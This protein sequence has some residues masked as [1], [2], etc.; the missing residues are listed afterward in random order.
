MITHPMHLLA[1]DLG[2]ESGRAMLGQFDGQRIEL[3]EMTRFPNV[4]VPL[5]DGLHWNTLN[6]WSEIRKALASAVATTGG[7]LA[8]MGI[9]TWGVDYALLDRTGAMIGSPFHYRDARNDGMMEALFQRVSRREVYNQTGIQF[10][11][12]NTLYQLYSM[13][14]HNHPQLHIADTL[15]MMPDLLNYWLTGRKAVEFSIATT[16]QCYDPRREAW[17]KPLLQRVNIP[18]HIFPEIVPPGTVLGDL[19][20]PLAEEAG[21]TRLPV[22]AP[23]CH[24]TGSAVAAVPASAPDFAWISSGTW[25]IM[26]VEASEPVITDASYECGMTNEGGVGSTIRLSANITGMW[27]VQE[28]RR[29][30]QRQGYEYSYDDLTRLAREAEPLCSI[31]DVDDHEFLKPGDMPARVRAFCDRTGQPV[32]ET[33]GQMVRCLFEGVALKYRVMLERLERLTGKRLETVHIV[34]GATRN[35]LLSQFAADATQRQVIT[36]PVE[37]TAAGNLLVQAIALGEIGSLAEAR[38]V[39]RRSFALQTYQPDPS[40]CAAW[41]D[42]YAK[43]NRFITESR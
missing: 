8:G 37:A 23:A 42:A 5:P 41:E 35:R 33:H 3:S 17:A 4:T 29:L 25:S 12:F 28:C 30:W 43:L 24:D 26:G 27:P 34:G 36:G 31:V 1:V 40:T 10:L 7:K 6:L 22:I 16:T 20:T 2:A 9:D 14:L 19:R 18:D 39:V 32:P 21:I 11:Q 38:E 15:L 13:V